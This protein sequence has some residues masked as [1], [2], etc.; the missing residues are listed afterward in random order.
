MH[1]IDFLP[2]LNIN[3]INQLTEI[4]KRDIGEIDESELEG[5]VL[6]DSEDISDDHLSAISKQPSST[7]GF[8]AG[9]SNCVESARA[10]RDIEVDRC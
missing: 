8:Q 6:F 7:R 4:I 1:Q 9:K 3:N 2:I 10:A 5:A